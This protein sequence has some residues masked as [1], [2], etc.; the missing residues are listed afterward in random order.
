[1]GL[2]SRGHYGRALPLVRDGLAMA[3]E[4]DH[5]EWTAYGH[6]SHGIIFGELLAWPQAQEHF[7]RAYTL[8]RSSGSLYWL[9]NTAGYLADALIMQGDLDAAEKTLSTVPIDLPMQALGQR[10]IW[11]SR[12]KLALARA[13]PAQAL[14]VVE[15]LF[16]SAIHCTSPQD[17]PLLAL[18]RGRCLSALARHGEAE[19]A[20]QAARQ[21]AVE[22]GARPL[23]WRICLELGHLYRVCRDNDEAARQFHSARDIAAELAATLP[24]DLRDGF[25]S[26]VASLL[27]ADRARTARHKDALTARERDVAALVARGLSN[28]DIG[29]ALYIGERTVE[30]HV[31]NILAKLGYTSRA[32]IA[33]WVIETDL[34][35]TTR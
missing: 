9:H 33:A 26:H 8:A 27:P 21:G 24:G 11:T 30:T 31:G 22:R 20:L 18:L 15:R 17:I 29:H 2:V 14:D 19:E 7:H 16:A 34:G 6:V 25:L 5:R 10:R 23:C 3:L 32:Q 1:M 13:D 28:R 4:I 35:R 12:A